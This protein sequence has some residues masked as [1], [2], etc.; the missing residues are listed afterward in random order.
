M[1]VRSVQDMPLIFYH[2]GLQS[3]IYSL[4][5]YSLWGQ[6]ESA[7]GHGVDPEWHL[8]SQECWLANPVPKKQEKIKQMK[9]VLWELNIR[10]DAVHGVSTLGSAGVSIKG[11]SI[12]L[13]N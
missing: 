13:V 4:P 7:K 8:Q 1:E 12:F 10:N 6:R 3:N 11:H 5:Q 2:S 9:T